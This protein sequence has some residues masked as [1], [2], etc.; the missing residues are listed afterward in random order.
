M[1]SK[2]PW[3]SK[4]II[5]SAV[6]GLATVVTMFVPSLHVI[7]DWINSN[8]AIIGAGWSVLAIALRAITKGSIQLSD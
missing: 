6:L 4:T 3:E 1:D 5:V 8:G 2:K 7:G